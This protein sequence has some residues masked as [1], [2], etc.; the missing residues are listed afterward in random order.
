[1]QRVGEDCSQFITH[2]LSC[3]FLSRGR[4]PHTSPSLAWISPGAAGRS[5][6]CCGLLW[7]AGEQLHHGLPPQVPGTSLSY[8]SSLTLVSAK[9][10][11]SHLTYSL[12]SY[13]VTSSP[14]TPEE[15][16]P[17]LIGLALT[18]GGSILE[19][20]GIGSNGHGRSF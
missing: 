17:L 20:H 12:L 14:V 4:T 19:L 3:S 10:L 1:M 15:L 6:L 13:T 8:P 16:L 9:L 18:S 5:L 7:A 2:C 11:L